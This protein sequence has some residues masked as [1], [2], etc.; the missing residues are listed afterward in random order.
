[1]LDWHTA[2][3]AFGGNCHEVHI[4]SVDNECK[5]L[6]LVLGGNKTDSVK[7]NCVNDGQSFV[8][9]YPFQDSAVDC[10][11]HDLSNDVFNGKYLFVPDASIMKAGCF[12][13]V[14]KA[15]GIKMLGKNSHLFVGDKKIGGFPGRMFIINNVSTMNKRE[16]KEKLR[17]VTKANISVRNFPLPVDALRKR[18]K[19]KDGGDVYL[20]ATTV[21]GQHL[22]FI[23]SKA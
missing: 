23:T 17:G 8:V 20:F 9:Y 10:L 2:V 14:S 11:E 3:K 5:E 7:L 13:E 4:V 19:L 18:L 16:L 21:D 22:I 6:L 15:F 1:M 12:A